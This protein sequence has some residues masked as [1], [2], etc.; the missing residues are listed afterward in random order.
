MN[1][2]RDRD[3]LTQRFA[4]ELRETERD[5]YAW[6]EG[7]VEVKRPTRYTPPI[8]T[9]PPMWVR[10]VRAAIGLWRKT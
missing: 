2:C 8:P 5:S 1:Y 4:R 6:W 7:P 10:I 9:E 3:P